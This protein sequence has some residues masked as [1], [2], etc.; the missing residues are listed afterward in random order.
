ME[1]FSFLVFYQSEIMVSLM[2]KHLT[3]SNGRFSWFVCMPFVLTGGKR[4][5]VEVIIWCLVRIKG[6]RRRKRR[7]EMGNKRRQKTPSPWMNSWSAGQPDSGVMEGRAWNGVTILLLVLYLASSSCVILYL[8]EVFT[9][10]QESC[11]ESRVS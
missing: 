6:K 9:D 1:I 8:D 2:L 10:F 5:E 11:L 3:A 4:K 7:E